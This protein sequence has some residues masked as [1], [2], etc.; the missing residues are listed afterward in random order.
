[1]TKLLTSRWTKAAVFAACLIPL[2]HLGWR[3]W[4]GELGANPIE[5][6]THRTGDWTL[7]FLA[8]TLCI[9]PLR[10][11]LKQPNLIRF[12]RMLGLFAFFYGALHFLTFVVLDKFFDFDAMVKDVAK[13]P[14]ITAGFTGF[15]LLIPLAITSTKGWI[16]RLGGK[17]WQMLHRAIYV[18][19]AAGAVHYFWLVKSDKRK[20]LF[21][22][23]V[24]AILLVYRASSR[25]TASRTGG[26]HGGVRSLAHKQMDSDSVLDR[27]ADPVR[28]GRT[29]GKPTPE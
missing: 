15:V 1:M 24:I 14:F 16:R 28:L 29:V 10:K 26:A 5:F 19:A 23:A 27:G 13:R 2:A 9:T 3:V 7:R 12:R 18:S 25:I 4:S 20:P 11:L 6:I 22:A 8:I 17:Q 21:Y